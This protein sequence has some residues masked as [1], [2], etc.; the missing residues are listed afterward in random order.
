MSERLETRY[1]P[2]RIEEEGK[3]KRIVIDDLLDSTIEAIRGRDRAKT[4]TFENMFNQIHSPSQVI[5]RGATRYDDGRI[6][7]DTNGTHALYSN[8]EWSVTP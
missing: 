4:V 7:V 3:K 1:L 2:I 5:A 8:F 6:H